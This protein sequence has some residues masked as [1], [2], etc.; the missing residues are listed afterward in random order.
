M[1]LR[2]SCAVVLCLALYCPTVLPQGMHL[3]HHAVWPHPK[4]MTTGAD[5]APRRTISPALKLSESLTSHGSDIVSAALQRYHDY[6]FSEKTGGLS[7]WQWGPTPGAPPRQC[8]AN[9]SLQQQGAAGTPLAQLSVTVKRGANASAEYAM[10]SDESYTL[11][12]P[13]TGDASL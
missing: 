9:A 10:G 8:L 11:D 12:I 4:L 13:L 3:P 7:M 5:D 6:L 2:A 1:A